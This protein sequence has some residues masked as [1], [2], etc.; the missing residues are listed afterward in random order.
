MS[1]WQTG[2]L[3]PG[4]IVFEEKQNACHVRLGKWQHVGINER[5]LKE[6]VIQKQRDSFSRYIDP[7]IKDVVPSSPVP[8]HRDTTNTTAVAR[9][10]G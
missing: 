4:S 7:G 8:T 1:Q 6:E 2:L 10:E 9:R 5:R 3:T